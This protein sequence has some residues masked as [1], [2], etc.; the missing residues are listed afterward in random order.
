MKNEN[1]IGS[2]LNRTRPAKGKLRRWSRRG[3]ISLLLFGF[4]A[5]I[6]TTALAAPTLTGTYVTSAGQGSLRYTAVRAFRGGSEGTFV[7][8]GRSY[9]GSAY[10]ATG[11][12]LGLVWY[13][14]YSGITAG[15]ALVT[16]QTNGIYSG[17]IWFFNR[18]GG[19]T[20]T[21]TLTLR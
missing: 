18:A 17:P 6:A 9:P 15:N 14:G 8:G 12:G 16:V 20:A 7:V 13:Y 3:V 21:G 11:G 2:T 5:S 19:T 10:A 1:L 4:I